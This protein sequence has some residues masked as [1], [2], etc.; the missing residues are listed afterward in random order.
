MADAGG[1]DAVHTGGVG[2]MAP[3]P[4][5]P[6][7]T[8]L[9]NHK[10][11]R[12]TSTTGLDAPPERVFA[13]HADVRNL[14]RITPGPARTNSAASPTHE[15]AIQVI[16]IGVRPFTLR[17]HARIT[18][19]EPPVRL[20]DEQLRGPFRH[21]RHTHTIVAAGR[22]AILVDRVEFRMIPGRFGRTIDQLVVAPALQILFAVRHA[23][24]R[25]ILGRRSGR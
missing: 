13:F 21:W 15:G 24:T 25:R 11:V 12:V 3:P 22:G 7:Y 2:V 10:P 16:E 23:R 9:M 19:F 8:G 6:A 4:A 1:A 17:W 14:P 5:P 18:R 20:V